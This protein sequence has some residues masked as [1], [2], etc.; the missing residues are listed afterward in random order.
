[1]NFDVNILLDLIMP[2]LTGIVGWIAG[3]KK[4]NNDFLSDLQESINLLS[5]RNKDLLQ[6]VVT[7]RGEN[8]DLLSNQKM[9]Q[10]EISQ[11]RAE[12][13]LLRDEVELL[14]ERLTGIKTITRA[15]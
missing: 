5:E 15:K 7:L 13:K 2:A 4:R 14:N 10:G 1:M 3:T 6:E 12:N 9:M 8:A 11:L